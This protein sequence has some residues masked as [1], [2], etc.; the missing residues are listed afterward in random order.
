MEFL[1]RD[2][3]CGIKML[4]VT[5][6]KFVKSSCW[7]GGQEERGEMAAPPPPGAVGGE[8]QAVFIQRGP[9]SGTRMKDKRLQKLRRATN[10][11]MAETKA[12][13]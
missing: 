1:P 6:P 11:T 8:Q 3:S 7:V 2:Y 13:L 10:N 9:G 12:S 4:P 5:I